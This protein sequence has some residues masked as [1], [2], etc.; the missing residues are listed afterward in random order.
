MK[1]FTDTEKTINWYYSFQCSERY[2]SGYLFLI[3]TIRSPYQRALRF[4]FHEPGY[5]F[6]VYFESEFSHLNISN[7]KSILLILV[8]LT[9]AAKKVTIKKLQ[10]IIYRYSGF[11]F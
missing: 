2:P 1:E 3:Q 9:V 8:D 4:S 5:D 11:K 10:K 7:E 6:F